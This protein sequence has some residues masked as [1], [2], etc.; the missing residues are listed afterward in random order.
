[1]DVEM[2]RV[3][4]LL[5]VAIQAGSSQRYILLTTCCHSANISS[6]D[7]FQNRTSPDENIFF[8]E[9]NC[10]Q[11][12]SR[13]AIVVHGWMGSC[14][15]DTPWVADT[16]SNLTAHRGGCVICM[17]YHKYAQT[18]DYFR[19]LVP[20]FNRIVDSLVWRLRELEQ[21]GF[22]PAEGLVFGFSFGAQTAMD[23]G[24]RFGF[25]KL[26]R[27]DVC[28]PAGPGFDSPDTALSILD[29]KL[30]ARN[31]QCIHTSLLGTTRRSCHQNW[32][33]GNCGLRQPGTV[34]LQESHSL[35]PRYYNSAFTNEFRAVPKP[36]ECF[37]LRNSAN[38]VN[39]RMGYFTD[40]E[41]G[42]TG[43]LFAETTESFPYNK[44]SV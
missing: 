6:S 27:I 32:N 26:G 22:D 19:G 1:M 5:L 35:C 44:I 43:D 42:A 23:A 7:Q 12:A 41:N 16:L 20:N 39:I 9:S 15:E 25:R 30:A 37:S 13:F 4:F 14:S 11:G 18:I 34:A 29:P 21:S 17:D 33:M 38:P 8:R 10:D 40:V 2:F 31:V 3:G 24:R 28:D 36:L